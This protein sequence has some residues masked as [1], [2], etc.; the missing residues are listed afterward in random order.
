MLRITYECV[1]ARNYLQ[2]MA[3]ADAA[4]DTDAPDDADDA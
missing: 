3:D 1:L 4:D 2:L